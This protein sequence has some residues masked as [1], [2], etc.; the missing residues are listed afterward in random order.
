MSWDIVSVDNVMN[1]AK[2]EENGGHFGFRV[3]T[4]TK[5]EQDGSS[6]SRGTQAN[7]SNDILI[8]YAQSMQTTRL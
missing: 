2:V 6:I 1:V 4:D 3:A 7:S 8:K 5:S